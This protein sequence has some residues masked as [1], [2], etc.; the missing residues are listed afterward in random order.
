MHSIKLGFSEE[1]PIYIMLIDTPSRHPESFLFPQLSGNRWS[2]LSSVQIP[3]PFHCT[4]WFSSGFL[5]WMMINPKILG[6]NP[7]QS[8]TRGLALLN[9]CFARRRRSW[10]PHHVVASPTATRHPLAASAGYGA[11][12]VLGEPAGSSG[13]RGPR[14]RQVNGGPPVGQ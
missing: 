1:V 7:L 13:D 8:S 10:L 11:P 5:Y 2:Q 4:A 12:A 9:W 6:I 14:P 3:L